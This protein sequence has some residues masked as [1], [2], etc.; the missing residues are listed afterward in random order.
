VTLSGFHSLNLA[1]FTLAQD[2][3]ERGM[4]AYADLQEQEFHAERSG[5]EATKHQQ[6]VGTGYFD[7]IQQVVTGGR[8]STAALAGST[9]AEQFGGSEKE[10]R[11]A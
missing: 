6:F 10:A 4:A 9:E 5:Y 2:Y 11:T 3:R 1:M 8:T 7:E